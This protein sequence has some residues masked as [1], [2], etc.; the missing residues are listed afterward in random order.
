ML[1]TRIS[2]YT[3]HSRYKRPNFVRE[4]SCSEALTMAYRPFLTSIRV[5]ND[6]QDKRTFLHHV[7]Q[8]FEEYDGLEDFRKRIFASTKECFSGGNVESESN[9]HVGFVGASNKKTYVNTSE[10]VEEAYNSRFSHKHNELVLF[11]PAKN[12]KTTAQKRKC[13]DVPNSKVTSISSCFKRN[14]ADSS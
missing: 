13:S 8:D 5:Y 10:Q 9:V 3:F 6:L 4:V 11:E 2:Y 7:V 12:K 1:R 14:C